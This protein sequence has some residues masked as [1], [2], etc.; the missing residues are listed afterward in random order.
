MNHKPRI[1]DIEVL[2]AVAVL[3][4]VYQHLR[5]LFPWPLPWLND[6]YR[7]FGGM[8]GVDLFFAVSGFVIARDLVPKLLAAPTQQTTWRTVWAF[9]LRRAWRLWPA[10]WLWLGVT[11]LAVTTFNSSGSFGSLSANLDAT[12]AGVFNFANIRFA[13]TFMRSEYGASFVYWSLS[14]EEQF[15]LIF[16]LL[17]LLLRKKLAW[18]LLA[19]AVLQIMTP[20]QHPY[21]MMFRTDALA[22][23]ILLALWSQKDAWRWISQRLAT[24]GRRPVQVIALLAIGSM[25]ALSIPK[26]PTPYAVGV[27]AVLAALLVLLA[28]QNQN[29]LMAPGRLKNLL[30][31][32]GERSY[33]L[34][35]IH[36]PAFF[37][38]R[39]LFH[40]LG[41]DQSPSTGV[42]LA[43]VLCALMLLLIAAE[44]NYRW[45]ETPLRQYGTKRAAKLLAGKSTCA[46][47]NALPQLLS[48]PHH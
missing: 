29:L 44:L 8:F 16:P 14:L 40:R 36:V 47:H 35:L 7:S 27:I 24:V 43:Y 22:L 4:V 9:W 41:L 11:L 25:A 30:I 15:Y 10:A 6:L 20:R 42:L 46:S 48:G 23:G 39:E 2:R 12:L 5:N 31:W 18:L 26:T 28:A 34:Y 17:I 19:I 21:L 37:A 3:F 45:V 32:I 33:A 13:Q 38:T 1:T